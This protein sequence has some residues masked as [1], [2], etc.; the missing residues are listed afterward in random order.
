MKELTSETF[1]KEILKT[2]GIVLVDFFA[3]WCGPCKQMVPML[4][5]L[6]SKYDDLTIFKVDIDKSPELSQR[7]KVGSV[8]TFKFI[9]SGR[10]LKTQ[11]GMMGPNDLDN[12]LMSLK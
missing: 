8:P 2:S 3:T 11:V 5:Q 10:V 7:F 6:D 1:D 4:E 9:K 12:I